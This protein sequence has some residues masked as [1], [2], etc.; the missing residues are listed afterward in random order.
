MLI[1]SCLNCK[2]Q[3]IRK[4][5]DVEMSRCRRE[6]CWSRYSK[7]ISSKA[8]DSFLEK[9]CMSDKKPFSAIAHV[10]PPE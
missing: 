9:E 1:K 5:G 7:C 3:E 4:E 8:L 2:Y 6:N 10:Y